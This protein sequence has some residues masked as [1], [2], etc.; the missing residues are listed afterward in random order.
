MATGS[1]TPQEDRQTAVIRRAGRS[2]THAIAELWACAGLAG[3]DRESRNEIARIR[4]RDPE[5][6][7]IALRDG[8]LIGAI[9]GS[10]DGRTA[11]VSRL[12]VAEGARRAGVATML[13]EEFTRQLTDLGANPNA[14]LVVDDVPIIDDL[15]RSVGYIRGEPVACFVRQRD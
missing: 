14:V 13:F 3:S 10:Y 11:A 9:A 6:L 15:M 12:A 4:R 8:E 5:L 7:L 2:D 1:W